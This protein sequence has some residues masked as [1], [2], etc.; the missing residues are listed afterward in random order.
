MDEGCIR[1]HHVSKDFCTPV[2]D[3]VCS[4]SQEGRFW[5]RVRAQKN[6]L[7]FVVTR[8]EKLQ[9]L[10]GTAV[11]ILTTYSRVDSKIVSYTLSH[12]AVPLAEACAVITN[13]TLIQG[14]FWY[15]EEYIISL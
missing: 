5:D 2:I 7:L 8:L 4:G 1:R 14:N 6:Q 13:T 3:K 10:Q 12:M 11:I 15:R 9:L